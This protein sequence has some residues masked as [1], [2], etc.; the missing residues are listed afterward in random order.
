MI[1][2]Y[3]NYAQLSIKYLL[4]NN[5]LKI[6]SNFSNYRKKRFEEVGFIT[7]SVKDNKY[8]SIII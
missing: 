7:T 3:K 4:F 5:H 8:D 2:N 6:F 1:Q